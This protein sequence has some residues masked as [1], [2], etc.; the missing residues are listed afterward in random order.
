MKK[1]WFIL[2]VLMC[3]LASCSD[4]GSE[5]PVTPNQKPGTSASEITIDPTI[6]SGGVMFETVQGEK[7]ITFSTSSDWSL[8]IAETRSGIDWCKASPTSGG[9]GT[10]NVKFTT[11][12]NTEPEDRSVAVTIK[13]GTTSKTFTI[14]QK[15]RDALLVTTKKYELSKEGGEIEIEVKANVDYQM[16]ISESAK[17]WITEVSG[18]ALTSHKHVL[19]I[20]ASEE[21]VKREGEITFK[22]GD[23]VE[24]V[25][26]YQAGEAVLLLSKNEFTVSDAGETISVDI[27]SNVE[28]GVQMPDVDWIQSEEASRAMSSHTL[29]FVVKANETYDSREAEIVFYDKNSEL[30]NTLKIIQNQKVKEDIEDIPYLTFNADALQTLTMSRAVVY[31]EYSV[32]GSEEWTEL[33]TNTIEFGGELGNL[34]LRGRYLYGTAYFDYTDYSYSTTIKF[35]NSTRVSCTGDIRTL[36]N[37]RIYDKIS[38][39]KA[40]FSDLFKGCV[41]LETAPELPITTLAEG[42]YSGMFYECTA[43]KDAPELPATILTDRCYNEMFYGCTALKE[44]P[45]L[46]ATTLAEGCYSGMFEGCTSLV[47]A[48]ELPA[49]TLARGCYSDMFEGCTSLAEAPKLPATT[50]A[51]SCYSY[52]FTGCISLVEAPELP[53]T[54]LANTCYTYMFGDC[55]ALAEAPELPAT[56]LAE[57]CY[58]VMFKGCTSLVK[59][60]ELPATTLARFCYM[61]MFSGCTNLQTAPTELPATEL[62]D[63]CYQEMFDDCTGLKTIPL[64]LPATTLTY[65]C[66]AAMFRNCKSITTAPKLPITTLAE[67]CCYEMFFHCWELMN[68]PTELPALVLAPSCYESMFSD[69]KLTTA[70]KLPATTLAEAC[71]SSMFN[72]CTVLTKAPELPAATLADKCYNRMFYGCSGL[73][74]APLLPATTLLESC[75]EYMFTGCRKVNSI[76]MLATDISAENCLSSWVFEVGDV[77]TFTKAASMTSLPSGYS[78]IPEGWEVKDYTE[79]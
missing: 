73:T 79:E 74:S 48:P 71:Y 62:S 21:A 75:Y 78:G 38:T 34:R 41:V 54:N 52:M 13:A 23:M 10:A 24:T 32:G 45:E 29:K 6:L 33:G 67:Y 7:S 37:Y 15:G 35:G 39:D 12:E 70:P 28:F 40:K 60:P 43:L 53:A 30:K 47:E 66:Y 16:E 61:G 50:L 17:E 42:C 64:E 1:V 77:G 46:P 56:T 49:I 72:G 63:R 59:A 11:S 5:T 26:V 14:T 57:H 25:K 65:A 36:I 18:R 44:T 55:T 51:E 76:T 3:I 19:N 69:T 2:A 4:G 31:L 68:A 9:K 27:K 22:S 8:S 20:A 58:W